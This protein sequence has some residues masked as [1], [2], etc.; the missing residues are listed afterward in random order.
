KPELR[1]PNLLVARL[2]AKDLNVTDPVIVA[3]TGWTTDEL[4][5]GIDAQPDLVGRK[6]DL[7]TL[8][9]G[10]NNQY[11]GRD[12]EDYRRQFDALLKRSIDFAGGK[13]SHV[14][15]LSIPDWGV[16]PLAAGRDRQQVSREIDA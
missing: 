8:Q 3:Q 4:A 6:F 12:V 5:A 10:V 16:T 1:W 7:V 2:R 13:P 15:V 14:I 9:I 11:R